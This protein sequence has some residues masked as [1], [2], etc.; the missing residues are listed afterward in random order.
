M[1]LRV[2]ALIVVLA[3]VGTTG[4]GSVAAVGMAARVVSEVRSHV[5]PPADRTD[6]WNP[7]VTPRGPPRGRGAD[8]P[9]PRAAA[10]RGRQGVRTAEGPTSRATR[11]P[12][13]SSCRHPTTKHDPRRAGRPRAIPRPRASLA[14]PPGVTHATIP[15]PL[16]TGR[17]RARTR[18][19]MFGRRPRTGPAARPR[20]GR[21]GK[22][23][24]RTG[25]RRVRLGLRAISDR[26]PRG[27]VSDEAPATLNG[28]S[29]PGN[30]NVQR[31][32]G[33]SGRLRRR[34]LS[35]A[36]PG[37]SESTSDRT[38]GRSPS[39]HG[40]GLALTLRVHVDATNRGLGPSSETQG[41]I[42]AVWSPTSHRPENRP[43]STMGHMRSRV[44]IRGQGA[45]RA[46]SGTPSGLAEHE[47]GETN[48]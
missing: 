41:T 18:K 9:G 37:R 30:A 27:R 45:E 25:R 19:L 1:L 14:A 34:V 40:D 21:A 28:N 44:R 17:R 5:A 39:R 4:I 2:Q 8:G 22:S 32:N 46:R 20:A 42:S 29:Q 47:E 36:A 6:T 35:Q 3:V 43:I 33:P 24:P 16:R 11:D 13:A 38:C 15:D 48:W 10:S 12:P 26:V 31:G 7:L 23:R